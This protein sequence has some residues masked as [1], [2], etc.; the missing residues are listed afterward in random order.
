MDEASIVDA[1]QALTYIILT[2]LPFFLAWFSTLFKVTIAQLLQ[3]LVWY[4]F[5]LPVW[6]F[7]MKHLKKKLS[8]GLFLLA[9]RVPFHEVCPARSLMVL[10][11]LLLLAFLGYKVGC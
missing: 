2:L 3:H 6:H 11:N 4:H 7:P 10:S 8:A 9:N 5:C 1:H